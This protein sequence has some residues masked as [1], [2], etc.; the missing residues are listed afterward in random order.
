MIIIFFFAC[1]LFL[2]LLQIYKMIQ[3]IPIYLKS[4]AFGRPITL[5]HCLGL[6]NSLLI[7]AKYSGLPSI[8]LSLYVLGRNIFFFLPVLVG[9]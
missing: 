6:L 3:K 1:Y 5:I 7:D 4:W 8:V 2:F 9:S